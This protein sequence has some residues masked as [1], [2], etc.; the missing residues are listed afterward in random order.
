MYYL[1]LELIINLFDF[2]V[3]CGVISF[4]FRSC[5]TVVVRCAIPRVALLTVV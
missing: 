1:Y 3:K 4:P 5:I 2:L